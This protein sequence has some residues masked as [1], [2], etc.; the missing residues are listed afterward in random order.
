MV[1]TRYDAIQQRSIFVICANQ[2]MTWQQ[3]LWFLYVA[4]TI[5]GLVVSV[6]LVLGAWLVV[7]FAGLEMLVLTSC[8]YIVA[9]RTSQREVVTIEADKIIIERGRRYAQQRRE[10]PRYWAKV[11]LTPPGQRG[12][13]SRLIISAHGAQLEIGQQLVEAERRQLASALHHA[14]PT[15]S[16]PYHHQFCQHHKT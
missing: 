14:I 16:L 13:A 12:H 8:L 10:L 11:A 7:P 15:H 5:T 4:F 6:C 1:S 9:C 3:N 2:S